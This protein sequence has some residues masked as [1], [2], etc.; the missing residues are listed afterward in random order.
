MESMTEEGASVS[1]TRSSPSPPPMDGEIR[2]DERARAAAAEDFGHLV[3]HTPEC[4]V[5][6]ASDEDVAAAVRRAAERGRPFAAQGQ[7]HS[8][9]GRAQ[10]RDGVVAD[11]GRLRTVHAVEPDRVVVDAGATLREVLAATLPQGLAPPGLP[12]YLD[13]SVGGT[14]VVGGVGSAISR[15]GVL[16]D[17][18]LE[19]R[20]VTGRGERLT[21]SPTSNPRLFDAV[22]AGLGQVAVI[23]RATLRLVPAP[24]QVRRFLLY[25]PDLATMLGDQRLLAA[26][27]RFEGVQG[28]ALPAPTGGWMFRLDL[29]KDLPGDPP[30]EAALLAGLSDDRARAE[31]STLPYLDYLDRLAALERLLRSE[32]WWPFPHPWLTTFV[33]DA[34]VEAVAAGELARL[35]PA[36]L[37]PLGQVVV[38]AI[39]RES[40]RTP[41]LRLPPD[42]L[43]FTFNLIRLPATDDAAEARRLVTANQAVYERV[44]DA[45]GSLYPVSAFP[46]SAADWR[47]HF[48]AAFDG[49][50]EAKREHDP[51]QALTPG[52]EVFQPLAPAAG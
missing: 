17:N 52:Y 37:G 41:L 39:L 45:G 49:L 12:D 15:F 8:V 46:M 24:R 6:P 34:A 36:D 27:R 14:L 29:V 51:G 22:R 18:V 28:A 43:C 42:P 10:V 11:M 2:S 44:R 1:S 19:L 35:T 31:P 33:G 20:V 23:T 32:G 25:Y 7:R 40:V 50:A 47:A 48:G 3:H 9:F 30:D 13:L 5:L 16:T 38:S 4:V 26:E 21:C